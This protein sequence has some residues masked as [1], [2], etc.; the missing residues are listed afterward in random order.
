MP[1]HAP[2]HRSGQRLQLS[3]T[4][5]SQQAREGFTSHLQ[6]SKSLTSTPDTQELPGRWWNTLKR[7]GKKPAKAKCPLWELLHAQVWWS[8]PPGAG[9]YPRWHRD[10]H[11]HLSGMGTG[12]SPWG[13]GSAGS[14][15]TLREDAGGGG[16][17]DV[18]ECRPR[19][20]LQTRTQT[21]KAR[22]KAV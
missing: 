4:L 20:E 8:D 11:G 10:G 12:I 14:T 7:Q 6:E 22:Q 13:S 3:Q 21:T 19:L 18:W 17:G 16:G 15:R 5:P 9:L 2:V 1:D